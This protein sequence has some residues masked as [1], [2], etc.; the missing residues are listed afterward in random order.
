MKF[1]CFCFSR[2]LRIFLE[3]KLKQKLE[4]T[5]SFF[6]FH[7][8]NAS[9][10]VVPFDISPLKIHKVPLENSPE[11]LGHLSYSGLKCA[12]TCGKKTKKLLTT[13]IKNVPKA[14][15]N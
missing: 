13:K 11:N 12:K 3:T 5:F 8:A 7:L 1:Y 10:I 6:A 9:F 14:K 15:Q 2:I 4:K